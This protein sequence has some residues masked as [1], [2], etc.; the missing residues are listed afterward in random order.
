LFFGAVTIQRKRFSAYFE[1]L[2]RDLITRSFRLE[3]ELDVTTSLG[4]E[5]VSITNILDGDMNKKAGIRLWRMRL[6]ASRVSTRPGTSDRRHDD[7]HRGDE[8]DQTE[9]GEKRALEPEPFDGVG[10]PPSGDMQVRTDPQHVS[11]GHVRTS[12]YLITFAHLMCVAPDVRGLGPET[13]PLLDDILLVSIDV[14]LIAGFD[15]PFT[16]YPLPSF[17]LVFLGVDVRS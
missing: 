10:L 6:A 3:F 12:S 5:G 7:Q 9:D 4:K 11:N 14:D 15:A 13:L 8:L 17:P 2:S 1:R 16:V